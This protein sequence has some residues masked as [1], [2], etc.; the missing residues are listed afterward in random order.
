[1]DQIGQPAQRELR[2]GAGP[3]PRFRLPLPRGGRGRC[4]RDAVHHP[5]MGIYE[6][7][8]LSRVVSTSKPG[9]DWLNKSEQPIRSQVNKLTQLL[10]MTTTHKFLLQPTICERYPK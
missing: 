1:M 7:Y 8:S 2:G 10:T 6:L 4:V 9:P 5:G 3:G